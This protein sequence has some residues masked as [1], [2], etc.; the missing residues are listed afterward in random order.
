MQIEIELYA[1]AGSSELEEYD[2]RNGPNPEE[3]FVTSVQMLVL[4]LSA[5]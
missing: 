1:N 5:L 4:K 2:E 3:S